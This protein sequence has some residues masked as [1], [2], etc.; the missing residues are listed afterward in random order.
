MLMGYARVSTADHQNTAVQVE[1]L[2]QAGVRRVFEEY[3]WGG[4]WEHPELHRMI[5]FLRPNACGVVWKLDR[6]S[7]S[8]RDLLDIRV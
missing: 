8:L 7:R 1:E 5:D 6:L 4:R 3:A 2:K